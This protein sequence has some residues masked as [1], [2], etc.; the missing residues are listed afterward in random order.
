MLI[1]AIVATA[2]CAAFRL[3]LLSFDYEARVLSRKGIDP[4]SMPGRRAEIATSRVSMW[5]FGVLAVFLWV[6][7]LLSWL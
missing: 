5:F 7:V 4:A 2:G 1:G 3:G 6:R